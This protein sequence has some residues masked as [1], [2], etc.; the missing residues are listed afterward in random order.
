[1]KIPLGPTP[2]KSLIAKETYVKV[3]PFSSPLAFTFDGKRI[4]QEPGV[5]I[6]N[7]TFQTTMKL[8]SLVSEPLRKS[9][10]MLNSPTI[11]YKD[12]G[13]QATSREIPDEDPTTYTQAIKISLRSPEPWPWRMRLMH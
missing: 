3:N 5:T 11:S 12:Q 8:P 13:A 4:K 10:R 9:E 7:L 2:I 1:M 6:T